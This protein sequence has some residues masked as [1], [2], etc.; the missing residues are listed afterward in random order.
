MTPF[1]AV[2]PTQAVLF[3]QVA[4]LPSIKVTRELTITC[5]TFECWSIHQDLTK[6][7]PLTEKLVITDENVFSDELWDAFSMQ[8]E[9]LHY[10]VHDSP[11]IENI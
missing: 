7:I 3:R 6:F 9:M 2:E 8:M 1:G 11:G 4:T 10:E 5:F